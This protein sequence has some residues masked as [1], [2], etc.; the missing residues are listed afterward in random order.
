MDIECHWMYDNGSHLVVQMS[1]RSMCEHI[2][3]H[4]ALARRLG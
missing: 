1:V 4:E 2:D 3:C